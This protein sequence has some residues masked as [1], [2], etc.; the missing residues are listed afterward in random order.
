MLVGIGLIFLMNLEN[1]FS[2]VHPIKS[3]F[4]INNN[5]FEYSVYLD[6]H[7]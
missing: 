2:E 1:S 5:L 6:V 3:N 7:N 4:I